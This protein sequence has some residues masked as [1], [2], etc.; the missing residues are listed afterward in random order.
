MRVLLPVV[1]SAI[2]VFAEDPRSLTSN[3]E[4][5]DNFSIPARLSKT[6]DTKKCKA[7]DAVEMK[8]VEPVLIGKG[9]VMPENAKLHGKIIGAASRQADRPSWVLLVV[10]RAEWKEHSVPLR[11][12]ITSQI[13]MRVAVAPQKDNTFDEAIGMPDTMQRRRSARQPQVN[14]GTTDLSAGMTHPPRESTVE[15]SNGQQLSYR[16]LDDV[17]LLQ[18]KHG[19]I[20]LLSQKSHLK[21]PSGSLF[22][23]RNLPAGSPAPRGADKVASSTQ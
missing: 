11:A 7:G 5:P 14:P 20:F 21:L 6:I 17:R 10:E 1:F 19:R 18:D 4:I 9:L 22:M 15:T 13:T 23:L 12:F 16:G 3:A 2:L 8:T